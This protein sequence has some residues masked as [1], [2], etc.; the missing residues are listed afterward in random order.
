MHQVNVHEAKTYLSNLI[1]RVLAGEE[2]VI[3]KGNKPVVKLVKYIESKPERKIGSA[4]G[5][6]VLKEDFDDPLQE[7]EEYM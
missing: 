2:V 7:F 4:K 3:A 6:I 5:K 1:K